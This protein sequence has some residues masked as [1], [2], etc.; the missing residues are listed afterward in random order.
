MEISLTEALRLKNEIS[1]SVKTLQHGVNYNVSYGTTTEDEE[2]ITEDKETFSAIEENLI[3]A[4][5]YSE[6]INQKIA[7][8][9]RESNVDSIVRKLQN[10]KLLLQVY[11]SVLPR[12]KPSKSTRFENLGN[13]TRKAIKISFEPHMSSKEVKDKISSTKES[14]RTLQSK[15]ETANNSK[16][17]LS[18]S[19]KDIENLVL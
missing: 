3:K 5:S 6:E 7:S 13:G 14:I 15:I 2:N 16:I 12:C 8:F 11:N 17:D 4:L 19:Y 9:N 10:H 1:S 18:F